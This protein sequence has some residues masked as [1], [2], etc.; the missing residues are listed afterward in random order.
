MRYIAALNEADEFKKKRPKR[1]LDD[2]AKTGADQVLAQN[3][4]EITVSWR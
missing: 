4:T 1:A 2:A 3:R